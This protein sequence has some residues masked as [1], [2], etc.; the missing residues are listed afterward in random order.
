MIIR[1]HCEV[2]LL[3]NLLQVNIPRREADFISA[4]RSALQ[5][6]DKEHLKG[7]RNGANRSVL[8]FNTVGAF[9]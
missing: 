8:L 4:A 5:G 1:L 7:H 6:K 2:L 9:S 3:L